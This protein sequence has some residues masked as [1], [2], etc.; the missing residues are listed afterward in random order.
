MGVQKTRKHGHFRHIPGTWSPHTPTSKS[1]PITE[2][3]TISTKSPPHNPKLPISL[4]TSLLYPHFPPQVPLFHTYSR[5]PK[6]HITPQ[7][8]PNPII[9]P[10]FTLVLLPDNSSYTHLTR[11]R[12]ATSNINLLLLSLK[13]ISTTPSP[14]FTH[15]HTAPHPNFL[16]IS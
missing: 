10:N 13:P 12:S 5:P 4:P 15:L 16:Y 14:V 11:F 1:T 2:S 8:I 9:I 3:F 6:S 7:H